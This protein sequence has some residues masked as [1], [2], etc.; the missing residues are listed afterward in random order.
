MNALVTD[1]HRKPEV[2]RES[3]AGSLRAPCDFSDEGCVRIRKGH[4]SAAH[5]HQGATCEGRVEG[6]ARHS[7]SSK[8]LRLGDSSERRH[9]CQGIHV[10]Q[11]CAPDRVR[12]G[13]VPRGVES[14]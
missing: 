10:T 7:R 5:P 13:Q 12:L 8:S 3:E 14:G 9:N 4:A 6:P 1:H 2:A 11:C